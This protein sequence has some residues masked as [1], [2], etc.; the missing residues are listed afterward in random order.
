MDVWTRQVSEAIAALDQVP[1]FGHGI[2]FP[3]EDVQE[4]LRTLLGKSSL[5][6][7]HKDLGWQDFEP[8]EESRLFALHLEPIEAP[9][10]LSLS[11]QAMR[12]LLVLLFD[13]E[14]GAGPFL[15]TS[16]VDGFTRF[17]LIELLNIVAETGYLEGLSPRLAPAETSPEGPVFVSD[18]SLSVDQQTYWARLTIPDTFRVAWQRHM[19]AM[20]TPPLSEEAAQAIVV[21]LALEVGASELSY[22][23]WGRVKEGDF[24]ILDRASYDPQTHKGRVVLTVGGQPLFRGKLEEE[25]IKLLEYPLYEEVTAMDETFEESPD[26]GED[27]YGDAESKDED[28]EALPNEG[29][30]P[31]LTAESLPVQ[32][33]VEVGRVRMSAGELLAL[34]AGNLLELPV[35]P[36][37]GVDLVVGGKRVG[38][39]EL[40]KMG[41]VLGVRILKL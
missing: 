1:Q 26:E 36:E 7:A 27:L 41:E 25:G 18:L 23:D 8:S 29:A 28:E 13:G 4:R 15:D 3:L 6:L 17:F 11:D 14:S 9:L 31:S 2:A 35:T 32:L 21:D 24:V 34:S 37:Q 30:G 38:K 19:A 10:Y 12:G 39:G 20:P 22:A 33:T 5:T 40:V 16:H